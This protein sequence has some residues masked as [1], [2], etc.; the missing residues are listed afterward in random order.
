MKSARR[1]SP[2][3]VYTVVESSYSLTRVKATTILGKALPDAEIHAALYYMNI[4]FFI[5]EEAKRQ[6][7]HLIRASDLG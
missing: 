6:G 1:G 4:E 2:D 7:V 5:E 3:P